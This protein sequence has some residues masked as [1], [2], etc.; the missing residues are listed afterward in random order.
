MSFC[1]VASCNCRSVHTASAAS[2]PLLNHRNQFSE[3]AITISERRLSNFSRRR[4]TI[5]FQLSDHSR[6]CSK[7]QLRFN[8]SFPLPFRDAEF[9]K[10]WSRIRSERS[11]ERQRDGPR[12]TMSRSLTRSRSRG[13]GGRR[14]S[15]GRR[16]RRRSSSRSSYSSSSSRSTS[17]RR[18]GKRR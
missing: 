1:S 10:H 6:N 18:R 15:R 17:R 8:R 14:R 3:V 11:K 4:W 5:Q 9:G 16:R 12:R 7:L 13:R 2:A